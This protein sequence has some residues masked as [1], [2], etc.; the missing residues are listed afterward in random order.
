MISLL[1]EEQHD[2]DS[3]REYCST[4]IDAI[5]DKVKELEHEIKSLEDSIADMQNAIA[6]LTDEV[7]ALHEGI[8]ALD[9]SVAEATETRKE[10]NQDF[11]ELMAADA[12]AEQLLKYAK[13]RLNKFYNPKIYHAPPKRELTEQERI[14]VNNGGTLA[15]T[16]A[17]GGI[18]GTG[19]ES[20]Y[21]LAQK[22]Q[23]APPPPPA[24]YGVYRKKGEESNGVIAMIDG[25]ILD[26][27]KEMTEAETDEKNSQAEYEELMHDSAKKR[28]DDSRAIQDKEA[29]KAELADD[30]QKATVSKGDKT[31]ELMASVHFLGTLHLECDWL[32]KNFELRQ[33][34]RAGELDA[35]SKAKAVLSGADFTLVQTHSSLRGR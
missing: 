12:A 17:P 14:L 19:V 16:A 15:P 3:K 32:L 8:V 29:N 24:Q 13:N 26:L 6:T 33:E 34:A 21:A 31:K 25:L 30:L 10:E 22:G 18:Q 7:K 28:A 20:P 23:A 1:K 5:E 11:T 27:Q 35:L 2:D 9:K 4:Q